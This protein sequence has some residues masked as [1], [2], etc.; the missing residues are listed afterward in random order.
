MS[1]ITFS[2]DVA[3]IF[4]WRGKRNINVFFFFLADSANDKLVIFLLIF[5]Q[6]I[7]FDI[8]CKL[9]ALETICMK[10]QILFSGKNKKNIPKC[11]LLKILLKFAKP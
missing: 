10:C 4:L 9:S 2:D 8:S 7:G 6:K 3:Q 5:S 11:C 1:K